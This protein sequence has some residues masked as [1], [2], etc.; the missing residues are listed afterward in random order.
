MFQTIDNITVHKKNWDSLTEAEK[1]EY[2]PFLINRLL[3][4]NPELV[5]IVNHIQKQNMPKEIQYKFW[6]EVLPKQRMYLK[7]PKKTKTD[8]YREGYSIL[9]KYYRISLREADEYFNLIGKDKMQELF[10]NMGYSEKE[11]KKLMK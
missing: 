4:T 10:V 3:S 6:F 2:N 5:D 1:K 11:I 7:F 8:K 9:A